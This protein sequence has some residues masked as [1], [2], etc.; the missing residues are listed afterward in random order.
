MRRRESTTRLP[1]WP[2]FGLGLGETM[3]AMTE[4]LP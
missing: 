1:I 2:Q 4:V 3:I